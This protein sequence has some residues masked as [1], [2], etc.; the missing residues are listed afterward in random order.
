MQY[1]NYG[2][3]EIWKLRV[4]IIDSLEQEALKRAAW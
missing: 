4:V 1:V 2:L 3:L